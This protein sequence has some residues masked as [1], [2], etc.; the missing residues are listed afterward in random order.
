M[1]IEAVSGGRSVI[2][3]FLELNKSKVQPAVNFVAN[4]TALL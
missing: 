4:K 2:L 3:V 1:K